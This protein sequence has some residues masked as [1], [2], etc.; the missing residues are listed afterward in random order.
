MTWRDTGQIW[1]KNGGMSYF[2]LRTGF[3]INEG[4]YPTIYVTW[5]HPGFYIALSRRLKL[6][7]FKKA[8]A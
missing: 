6:Y 4:Q 5:S 7:W 1:H 2:R 8:K 3:S